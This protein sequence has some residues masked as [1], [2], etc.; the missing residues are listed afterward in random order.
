MTR[1]HLTRFKVDSKAQSI[2]KEYD[3]NADF[4]RA[5]KM[6]A[7]LTIFKDKHLVPNLARLCLRTRTRSEAISRR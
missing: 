1:S 7:T 6:G 5:S 4:N 2:G 3:W